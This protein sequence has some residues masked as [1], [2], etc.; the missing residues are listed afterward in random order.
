MLEV[1]LGRLYRA[2]VAWRP[3]SRRVAVNCLAC[4]R[5]PF[6]EAAALAPMP[7]EVVHDFLLDL[8]IAVARRLGELRDEREAADAVAGLIWDEEPGELGELVERAEDEMW[9]FLAR[10]RADLDR[11][12]L[13]ALEPRLAEWIQRSAFLSD[14]DERPEWLL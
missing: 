8:E 5:S 4:L 2:I 12:R 10:R 7:H 9:A 14:L 13:L 11:V 6:R 3:P 1:S